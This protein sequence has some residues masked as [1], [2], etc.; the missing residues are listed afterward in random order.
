MEVVTPV[1]GSDI[2]NNCTIS[3]PRLMRVCRKSV[4]FFSLILQLIIINMV[5]KKDESIDH[6]V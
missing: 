5:I 2:M 6:S 4:Y 3:G 1:S